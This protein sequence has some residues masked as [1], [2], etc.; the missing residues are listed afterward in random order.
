MIWAILT[1]PVLLVFLSSNF[2]NAGNLAFNMLFSRWMGPAL[3]GDLAVVLTIKLALL[4]V[5]G[6]VQMAVT[7]HIATHGSDVD[8]GIAKLNRLIF[9]ALWFATPILLLLVEAG[10]GGER[11]GMTQPV[12]LLIVLMSLPFAAP[13]SILRGVVQGRMDVRGMLIS[14]NAEMIVRLG[15]AILLWQLGFGSAGVAVAIGLSIVAGWAVIAGRLPA[16]KDLSNWSRPLAKV[17][18]LAAFPFAVLQA[19][20]VLLLDG[21]IL[22]AK[23]LFDEHTAGLIAAVGLFQRIEFFACFGLVAVLLPVVA[24]TVAD[25]RSAVHQ[26]VPVAGLFMLVTALVLTAVSVIPEVLIRMMVG[27]E[28]LAA[29][30][31]LPFAAGAAS[32]FTLSYLL[33]TFLAALGDFRGVWTIAAWVPVQMGGF[34]ISGAVSDGV[35]TPDDLMVIKLGCQ[36]ALAA[37]LMGLAYARVRSDGHSSAEGHA[38]IAVTSRSI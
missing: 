21:E 6:A 11:L 20:Q 36:G 25:G 8:R 17:L 16:E 10:G 7:R 26:A 27:Q 12:L 29:T 14:A 33:A 9:I 19:S 13:L 35:T 2:V 4:G 24:Q 38:Q 32:A 34:F 28:Y 3:F 15:G 1:S 30:N 18:A 22:A 37:V 5:L 23:I 31:L